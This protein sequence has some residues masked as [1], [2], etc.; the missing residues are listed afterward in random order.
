V[1]LWAWLAFLRQAGLIQ[2]TNVL[3]NY[4]NP[5]QPADPSDLIWFYPGSW[6]G[7]DDPVPT[8]QL[9][10]VRRAQQDFEYLY[11][12]GQICLLFGLV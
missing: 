10:W 9:K 1:R 5:D 8:V 7:V 12:T 3:P 2:W 11:R 4:D 6:F